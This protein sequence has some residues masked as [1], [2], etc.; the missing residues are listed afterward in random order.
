LSDPVFAQ[1]GQ[2]ILGSQ[3]S[4]KIK[5]GN[6]H[7]IPPALRNISITGSFDTFGN[8]HCSSLVLALF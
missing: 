6:F 1:A 5:N 3:R 2:G 8:L 4:V 7:G